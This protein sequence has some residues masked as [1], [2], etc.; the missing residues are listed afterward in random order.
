MAATFAHEIGSPLSAISTHLELI[1]E[2]PTISDDTRR[3]L[4]LTQDQ[5]SRIT[6]FVEELLS[7]T[8]VSM[9]PRSPVQLNRILRQLLSFF[10]QHLARCRVRVETRF[11]PDLPEIEANPQQ[12]QQVFLNLLN[13]A[14]DAMPK[15]GTIFIETSSHSDPDGKYV[16]VSVADNGTGIPEEKQEHIFEPFFTTKDLRRGT[17][18]GLSIAAKIIRQHQG[19]IEVHS[20][21]GAGTTFT[22]R[23]RVPIPLST[24]SQEAL[25]GKENV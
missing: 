22:I 24:A 20:R 16:A 18:L 9:Q 15:G 4:K 12:L 19:T 11:S 1:A 8:R 6:G 2:D 10:E 23:F 17:G 5:V 21:P 7:E 14:C 25:A 3:R 13:N